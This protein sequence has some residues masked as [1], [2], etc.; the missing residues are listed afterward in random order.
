MFKPVA[1]KGRTVG[2]LEWFAFMLFR[3]KGNFSPIL[4]GH[5]LLQ[6]FLNDMYVCVETSRTNH[7]WYNQAAFKVKNYKGVRESLENED[8]PTGKKGIL[9]S[10][11]IGGPRAMSQLYQDAMAICQVNGPLS[12]FITM[13]ANPAWQEI[14]DVIPDGANPM[15]CPTETVRV[16]Y[17]KL[18]RLLYELVQMRRLG[19]VIAYVL[20]IKFQK[21]GLPHIH[22]MLTLDKSDRPTTPDEINL[23]VSAE[24]PDP[25]VEP[26]LY[27]I[28]TARMFHGPCPGRACW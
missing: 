23:L 24:I 5:A 21:R 16:T 12:L 7:I 8:D 4:H 17:L 15:D 25:A 22:V 2:S 11:F 14:K 1:A 28:I 3:R 13:T 18:K 10:T 9:P 27:D 20:T 26:I 6:E 19:K